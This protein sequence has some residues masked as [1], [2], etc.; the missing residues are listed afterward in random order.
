MNYQ[1]ILNNNDATAEVCEIANT[2]GIQILKFNVRFSIPVSPS[3]IRLT[4]EF[5]TI[6]IYS[7]WTPL[8]GGQRSL[9]PNWS[10]HRTNSRLASGIPVH[11][12]TSLSGRNRLTVAVSDV[13]TPIAITTGIREETAD[14]HCE[15]RFFTN[16][17][18]KTDAYTAFVRLDTR[19]IPYEDALRDVETWWQSDC[20][21]HPARTPDTALRPMYS[22]WY[23]YHQSITPEPLLR[24]CRA[25]KAL[26]MDCI[27]VDDGWQTGDVNRGYAYCGDWEPC[28]EKLGDMRAFVDAVHATGMKIMLWYAVAN[29]GKKSKKYAE[30][31]SML[32][33]SNR[34]THSILDP[35][36][37]AV[38]DYLCNLYETALREWDLDGFKLDFIDA[39]ALLPE[40]PAYDGR[41]DTQ[42]LE[43]GVSLLLEEI[44]TRL[45]AI[46]PDVLLEFRQSYIGPTVRKYG[47]MLRVGDCPN[48]AFR[49][50]TESINLR[51]LSATTAVHS[52]MIMWHRDEPAHAAARQLIHCL[53]CV[54]QISV[55][56]GE[57]SAEQSKMLRFYLDF[58]NA[59]RDVLLGGKLYAPHPEL[60]YSMAYAKKD[61]VTVAAVYTDTVVRLER[62]DR[63]SYIVNG[64]GTDT[65][66]L[67]VKDAAG[68]KCTVYTC[69]GKVVSVLTLPDDATLFSLPIPDSGMAVIE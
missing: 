9:R 40:T 47:N 44:R 34:P 65:V 45:H 8:G 69:T 48:D 21:Y 60:G 13:N 53:F 43:E 50:R 39:F 5:P 31:E 56:L 25:A 24:E 20:G 1:I 6:D 17:V 67:S 28:A 36:Y 29:I 7:V 62:H 16:P 12:L 15:I 46:K 26:G 14:T 59:H 57:I 11:A 3:E 38:R 4:W 42:I 61:G 30:F 35:R 63:K 52:D 18:A 22:S 68:A 66:T 32:L 33:G 64:S 19:D 2:D 37:P 27:I 49:N 55:R 10:P 58:W 51:L 41:R 54:P 23:S